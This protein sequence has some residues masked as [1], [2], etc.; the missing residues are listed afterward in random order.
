MGSRTSK[1]VTLVEMLVVI[2]II[3]ILAGALIWGFGNA[4]RQGFLTQAASH[5]GEV[6]MG[7]NAFLTRNIDLVLD[8]WVAALPAGTTS[9][10]PPGVTGRS[11]FDCRTAATLTRTGIEAGSQSWGPAPQQVGCLVERVG[12]RFLVHTWVEG[13]EAHFINGQRQ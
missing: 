5:G 12:R 7:L 11:G 3:G 6:S 4:R 9:G 8:D 10:G 13:D 2:A 1:G